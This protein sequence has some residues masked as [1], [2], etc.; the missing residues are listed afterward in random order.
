[1]KVERIIHRTRLCFEFAGLLSPSLLTY[2]GLLVMVA[3]G[4]QPLVA[5]ESQPKPLLKTERVDRDPGWEGRNNHAATPEARTIV[6]DFGFSAT[7]HAGGTAGEI[8]GLVCPA[9]EPAYYAKRIP[10]KTFS[11]SLTAS[12]KLACTGRHFHALVGFFNAGTINEWRTPNTIVLRLYGRGKVAMR[13]GV[14]D[15]TTLVGF[16]HSADSMAVSTS[17]ASQ[18]PRSSLG[19]AIEGPSREGFYFYPTYRIGDGRSGSG[20]SGDP[21]RIYPDGSAHDWSLQYLPDGTGSIKVTLGSRSIRLRL[22]PDHK[23]R[24]ARFD[25]FGII[26]TWI[27]GNGQD[28]Y[29]DDLNYTSGPGSP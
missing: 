16:Y 21:P 24:G 20:L 3:A 19:I 11:D 6:Q 1:M 8:G 4:A 23:A 12:G 28:V 15:S 26:T 27:D 5:A 29:F 22:G 17:Q 10:S 14:S 9:G 25:R 2:P 7:S 13:R 18:V